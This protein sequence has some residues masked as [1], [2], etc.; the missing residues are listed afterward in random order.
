MGRGAADKVMH[1]VV[2]RDATKL[3]AA[4]DGIPDHDTTES[5]LVL[6]FVDQLKRGSRSQVAR[7]GRFR[8]T[9]KPDEDLRILAGRLGQVLHPVVKVVIVNSGADGVVVEL[10]E[11]S[12]ELA[13]VDDGLHLEVIR[14]QGALRGGGDQVLLCRVLLGQGTQPSDHCDITA[15]VL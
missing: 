2:E 13:S 5:R 10:D 4:I 11:E 7:A 14:V 12:I 1:Q 15:L 8:R 3:L 9:R 6:M